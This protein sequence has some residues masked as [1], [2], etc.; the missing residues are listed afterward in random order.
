MMQKIKIRTMAVMAIVVILMIP[1]A[2]FTIND[3]QNIDKQIAWQN[4][5]LDKAL[6]DKYPLLNSI[7]NELFADYDANNYEQYIIK[8]K[9]NY[10]SEKQLKIEEIQKLFEQ[11]VNLLLQK[12]VI[13]RSL[14]ELSP[15][16]PFQVNFGTIY[17]RKIDEH[18]TYN[19]EQIYRYNT[20]NDNSVTFSINAQGKK[21]TNLS[22]ANHL[23]SKLS[24]AD[25]KKMTW[26]MI[27]Y[28]GLEEIDDWSYTDFGYESY[29]AKLQVVSDLSE[30][31]GSYYLNISVRILGSNLNI[32]T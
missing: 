15:N 25:L 2:I 8:N 31:S 14:L 24:Q 12:Q 18:G 7:Y 19:L 5:S 22:I 6:M 3:H 17:D 4:T 21:I 1:L 16:E 23:L 20:D 30:Y 28:L 11:E 13:D 29:L 10:S 27:E 32:I 26:Q 9:D